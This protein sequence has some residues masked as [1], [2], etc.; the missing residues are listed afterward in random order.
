MKIMLQPGGTIIIFFLNNTKAIFLAMADIGITEGRKRL[1]TE[2]SSEAS[3][4]RSRALPRG[5][6]GWGERL[7]G[8]PSSHSLP[9]VLAG[10][11]TTP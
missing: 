7:S 2:F 11:Q 3:E 1:P 6:V 8:I 9:A 4:A 5:H 10:H